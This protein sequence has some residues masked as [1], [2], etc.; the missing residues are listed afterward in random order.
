MSGVVP[1]IPRISFTDPARGNGRLANGTV[2]VYLAGTST[3]ANTYQDKALTTLN[4][5]PITLDANGEALFWVDD[6][7]DYKFLVKDS[8]GATVTGW[9][10]DNIQ[11]SGIG[12]FLQAAGVSAV[13]RSVM[14]KLREQPISVKDFGAVGDGATDDTAAV[15][16]ALTFA[17]S[18]GSSFTRTVQFPRG[19][20]LVT[21]QLTWPD[22]VAW[23]GANGAYT[24]GT[25]DNA[26][27]A[28][29]LWGGAA[30]AT[31]IV[32]STGGVNAFGFQMRN[33]RLMVPTGGNRPATWVQF[34]NRADSFTG[35]ENVQF[36]RA[37]DYSV[38]FEAGGIN[39]Y[40]NRLRFDSCRGIYWKVQ[41]L[42]N[43]SVRDATM[44][45]TAATAGEQCQ[46]F[47]ADHLA[48]S[49]GARLNFIFENINIEANGNLSAGTAYF[50]FKPRTDAS[51]FSIAF[52]GTFEN[53]IVKNAAG[54]TEYTGVK[55]SPR[56]DLVAFTLIQCRLTW[57]GI[58]SVPMPALG[59][60]AEYQP[61]T[62][63]HPLGL[64]STLA[65]SAERAFVDLAGDVNVR[66][67]YQFGKQQIPTLYAAVTDTYWDT[68]PATL[69]P[70]QHVFDPAD[71]NAAV[72]KVKEV[73]TT[74]T[75]GTLTGV[76]ATGTIGTNTITLND[77]TYIRRDQR[78]TIVGDGVAR[79]ISTIDYN[80]GVATLT[81]NLGAT[82]TGAAVA[83]VAPVYR[84]HT[85]LTTLEGSVSWDPGSIA[86][87]A[88]LQQAVTVTGAALG[89]YV[90]AS[91]S[92]SLGGLHLNAEVSATD[93][94]TFTLS[95][96]SGGA[97]DLGT[98]TYR[99]RVIK[100]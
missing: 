65:P 78:I 42:D 34:S 53:V 1:A 28:R 23:E 57:T 49:V 40:M 80:T 32:A 13:S 48:S 76:T 95:N 59:S 26:M 94:V 41:A 43:V 24:P 77:L 81:S 6:A 4:T 55:V 90:V 17:A 29:I 54:V 64:Q 47:T 5:N 44:D 88:Q 96:A 2:T 16:A 50:E 83:F 93:T 84:D 14:D 39:V 25:G 61:L 22:G 38:R 89:D 85:L 37:T 35:F 27:P 20:Y 36:H 9:P 75:L 82:V 73:V 21:S 100:Q 46:F 92:I 67:L 62:V 10:V 98:A 51:G 71:V 69:Y 68:N 31:V 91:S 86:N 15:Q 30:G 7:Y 99:A 58:P 45:H 97:V 56:T 3:L 72:R 8:S 87:G 12:A 60:T 74:G 63:I 66:A 52:R 18:A 79:R 33:L 70:G 19:D 11:A